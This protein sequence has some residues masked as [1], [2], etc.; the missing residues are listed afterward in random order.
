MVPAMRAGL[1]R[2]YK[3]Q[4]LTPCDYQVPVPC[5][6]QTDMRKSAGAA[7]SLDLLEVLV[8]TSPHTLL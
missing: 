4:I 7:A 5:W 8:M 1:L 3:Q 6:T 2:A